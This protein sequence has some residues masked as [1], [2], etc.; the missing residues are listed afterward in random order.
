[1][2]VW[3]VLGALVSGCATSR[4]VPDR[5]AGFE[6]ERGYYVYVPKA[7]SA[8][9]R[10]EKW[11]VIVYLHGGAERGTDGVLP[12]QVGLGPVVWKSQG[13]FPFIVIFPQAP[14]GSFWGAPENN[15]RVMKALYS[16]LARY[17]GDPNR[18][19][20]TGNSLGGFGTYFMAAAYPDRFAAIV[21]ICGGV[22]GKAP[23]PDLPFAALDDDARI[24][25]VAGVIGTTPAWIFHGEADWVVPVSLSR[26]MAAALKK[27][28]GDVRL[29]TYPGVGHNSWDRA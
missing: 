24:G 12:T 21:P 3:M 25:A 29:T 4:F 2:A 10:D 23:R 20:L 27:N 17:H 6:N 19:Y 7:W 1:M 26:E 11:P 8:E 9:R 14:K 18:V 16:V 15:E 5:A 22:R 28:G 13:T